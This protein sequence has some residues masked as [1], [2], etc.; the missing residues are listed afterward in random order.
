MLYYSGL[1]SPAAAERL[2]QHHG[3]K[4]VKHGWNETANRDA[5]GVGD[6]KNPT[7]L[8]TLSSWLFFFYPSLY[9]RR[10]RQLWVDFEFQDHIWEDFITDVQEDW[11]AS[12][13]PVCA[14]TFS[15]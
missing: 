8:F 15:W 13:T 7:W 12:I 5:R 10:L 9:L 4:W 6:A 14:P 3:T 2:R 1:I 11:A